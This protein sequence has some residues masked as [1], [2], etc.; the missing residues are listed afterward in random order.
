MDFQG[1]SAKLAD[2]LGI[3]ASSRDEVI[4]MEA[5]STE[6]TEDVP[7]SLGDSVKLIEGS[8]HALKVLGV[9]S[10]LDRITLTT[11][12]LAFDGQGWEHIEPRSAEI[13]AIWEDRV[14][15]LRVAELMA[16]VYNLLRDRERVMEEIRNEENG[17]AAVAT[18]ETLRAHQ[19][20]SLLLMQLDDQ[21]GCS[22]ADDGDDI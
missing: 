19:E 20:R 11:T 14:K 9:Q 10:I 18:D 1:P 4:V 8:I 13:P 2:G 15:L 7:H 22:H 12:R 3:W 5:S 6:H 21:Q 17:L 16:T